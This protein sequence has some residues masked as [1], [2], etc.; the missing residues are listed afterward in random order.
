[1]ALDVISIQNRRELWTLWGRGKTGLHSV[2]VH[3]MKP[4]RSQD[5]PFPCVSTP[6]RKSLFTLAKAMENN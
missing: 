1:M 3:G 5:E 4:Q 2:T 6:Q